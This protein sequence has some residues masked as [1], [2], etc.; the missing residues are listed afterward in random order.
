MNDFKWLFV[1]EIKGIQDYILATD[2]LKHMVGASEIIASIT[3]KEFY[4]EIV[5][6]TIDCEYDKD[7]K[8][9]MA[10]AGR[11]MLLFKEEAKYFDFY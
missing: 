3:D 11:L 6:K 7:Y 2:K 4:D 1:S 10:A 8:V 9:M 5:L